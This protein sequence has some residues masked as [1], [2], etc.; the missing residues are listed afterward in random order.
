MANLTPVRRSI[1]QK[2]MEGMP[3]DEIAEQLMDEF[4]FTYNPYYISALISVDIPKEIART[5]TKNRLICETPKAQLKV[6]K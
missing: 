1:A 6:C 5:A 3:R 2:A 4:G